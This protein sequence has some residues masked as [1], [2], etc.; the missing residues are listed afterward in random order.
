MGGPLPVYPRAHIL[1]ICE[2][3]RADGS[4]CRVYSNAVNRDEVA[5]LDAELVK[6]QTDRLGKAAQ[7][8]AEGVQ[9]ETRAVFSSAG[10]KVAKI[11]E[12]C[13]NWVRLTS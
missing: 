12:M 7:G 9:V 6:A 10:P 4:G 5:K 8:F 13:E 1:M 3:L 11:V 2:A